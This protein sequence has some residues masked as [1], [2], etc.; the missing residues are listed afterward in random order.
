MD[1][2]QDVK[3]L[4]MLI[5]MN[6]TELLKRM[7]E[8]YSP[9]GKEEKLV[10][11]LRDEM[12]NLGFKNVHLDDA[13]NVYGEVGKGSPAILLCGHMDTVPGWIPVRFKDGKIYG[14]GAVDAKSSLAAMISAA[15]KLS[16]R[17]IGGKIIIAGVV[18][19]EKKARG[20]RRLLREHVKVD[21]AIFG[22]P[23]G[24]DSITFAYKGRLVF[25][26]KCKT[27]TGHVGAQHLYINAIEKSYELWSNLREEL[28]KRRS[29]HGIFYSVTSCLT[30]IR[31]RRSMGSIPD[32]CTL[33]MDVRLP[34]TVKCANAVNIIKNVVNRFQGENPEV[35]VDLKVLDMVEPFVANRN[36][37][38]MKS[39]KESIE[40]V[41]HKSPR[42][43]RKTGTGDMNIFGSETRIPVA[44]YGP[45]N[46]RLSHTK[47]EYIELSEYETSIKVYEK[48]VEKII[49]K[50]CGQNSP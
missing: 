36:T 22:E 49:F 44:T 9:S 45:G 46:S 19:E 48:T 6:P 17:K 21:Y 34:P 5:E 26:I 23:S 13:G 35:S 39:L 20:I 18:D 40:E 32:E 50:V 12:S 25:R 14:R 1:D 3:L 2:S 4:N 15:Y 8:I 33:G 47:H 7:L 31:S 30:G 29:P 41:L 38:L 43:V 24:V 28:E 16:L 11:F 27:E 42:F 37:L 10:G